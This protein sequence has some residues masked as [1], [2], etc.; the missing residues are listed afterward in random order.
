MESMVST[1]P[2]VLQKYTFFFEKDINQ[3]FRFYY[4]N[5][6]NISGA[7]VHQRDAGVSQGGAVTTR[8]CSCLNCTNQVNHTFSS[9]GALLAWLVHFLLWQAAKPSGDKCTP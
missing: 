6:F 4:I 9:V 8:G 5:I 7:D 3:I 1:L 2:F